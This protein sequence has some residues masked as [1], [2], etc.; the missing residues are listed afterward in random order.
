MTGAAVVDESSDESDSEAYESSGISEHL[1][2]SGISEP[3]PEQQQEQEQHH[4]SLTGDL[5]A[6]AHRRHLLT[7]A[8]IAAAAAGGAAA[9]ASAGLFSWPTL[10]HKQHQQQQPGSQDGLPLAGDWS[11]HSLQGLTPQYVVSG[12]DGRPPARPLLCTPGLV[13]TGDVEPMPN[14]C[15]KVS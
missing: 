6:S 7:H 4:S 12:K 1:A 10:S 3:S 11:S 2:S 9:G 15:V 8:D 13:C 5:L 14:T